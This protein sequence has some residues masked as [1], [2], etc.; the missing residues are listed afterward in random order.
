MTRPLPGLLTA[1]GVSVAANA[2][3]AVLVPWLVLSRTGSPAQAGLVGAVALAAAVPA[4]V[5]G[6]PLI[7]RWGRRRVAA[8]ADLLGA[9]A[10]AALPV[11]DLTVGLGLVAIL[12]LV[13][14]GAVFDGPGAA[15]R[16]AARPEVARR[17]GT[18]VDA[19]NARGEAVEQLGEI[20]GPA[21]A[22]VGIGVVGAL[23]S[24]WV[25]AGLL[26]AAAVITWCTPPRDVARAGPPEPYLTAARTGF[27]TVWRDRTLRATSLVDAVAMVFF[28]PLTLIVTT[29]LQARGE[30]GA[31]ALVA[32]AVGVGGIL[33]AL[34][35]GR[36]ATRLRRR[37]L[38]LAGLGTAAAGLALMALLPPTPVLAVLGFGTGAAL[39]PVG[40]ALA[41]ITQARTAPALR[42]RVVSTQWSLALIATPLG[43]LGAGLLLEW[44]DPGTA[45]LAA[46]AGVLA[47]ALLAASAAG[48]RDTDPIMEVTT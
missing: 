15:A 8:A 45:L 38:L 25:A 6:G 18:T 47:T 24:L 16:E 37:T 36:L 5:L 48:L 31:L 23:T 4:L 34:A 40:P 1:T 42:G 7:D 41:A 33:G 22:G 28:A 9:V 44:T 11:L 26:L 39:G 2:M 13:A 29:H 20:A 30:P 21:V 12:T 46:A 3:V 43:V 32:T 35:Y 14:A 17:S 19:V 10:V 27:T